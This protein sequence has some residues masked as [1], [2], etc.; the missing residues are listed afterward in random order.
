MKHTPGPYKIAK[1]IRANCVDGFVTVITD[2]RG[3]GI[4]EFLQKGENKKVMANAKLFK[5]APDLL[6]TLKQIDKV[7]NGAFLYKRINKR[8]AENICNTVNQAIQKAE[9][10]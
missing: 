9:G 5:A 8:I 6:E 4:V 3:H 10:R 1:W 7:V 2:S